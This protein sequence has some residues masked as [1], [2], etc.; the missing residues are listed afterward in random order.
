MKAPDGVGQQLYDCADKNDVAG[1]RS[2]LGQ[3]GANDVVNWPNPKDNGWT[4]LIQA[5][6]YGR[7]DAVKL[8]LEVPGIDVNKADNDGTTALT[9]ASKEE[10]KALL[11]A[12]G[13]K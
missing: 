1:L 13:A 11:R 9:R 10:I 4:P 7:T 12:K 3:W 5:S 2:L 8:L 6:R